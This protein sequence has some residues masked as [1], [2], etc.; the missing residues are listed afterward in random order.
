M[1]KRQYLLAEINKLGG[2]IAPG[3]K[4]ATWNAAEGI[5]GYVPLAPA[6]NVET[7]PEADLNN[8]MHTGDI[9]RYHIYGVGNISN[10]TGFRIGTPAHKSGGLTG[11][12]AFT[13]KLRVH[14]AHLWHEALIYELVTQKFFVNIMNS[15]MMEF[16]F[17]M[18][19]PK[20]NEKI[21]CKCHLSK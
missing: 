1:Y 2:Y 18:F 4:R 6:H 16:K 8:I 19:L 10:H 9:R 17:G 15:F 11:T 14:E 5:S 7:S 3:E 12:N 21:H 13:F 20:F